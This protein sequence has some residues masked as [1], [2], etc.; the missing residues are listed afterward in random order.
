MPQGQRR[1][2]A[3][4]VILP[5]WIP[6]DQPLYLNLA[7]RRRIRREFDPT[8]IF[9]NIPYS[10]R[11][12]S[13]EVAIISTVTAYG[14]TPR[15]ARERS[16]TE[17]RL[18][19]IAELILT[20]QYGLTD[21]SYITRMNIPLELGLLLAFGKETFIASSRRYGALRTISDLNFS[22]IHYHEGRVRKLI[23]TLSRWIEQNCSKKRLKTDT[24][25]Q[26]YRRLRRLRQSLGDDFDRLRPQEIS[27]LLGVAADEFQMRL[28]GG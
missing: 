3:H 22:D 13:L 18:L 1:A 28:P 20:C 26:R 10:D 15:M 2:P 23:V 12:S 5:S 4:R 19:R 9:L 6:P 17:M 25:L 24:L 16:R 27:R 8:G 21:L 11:Y 7:I 14:L